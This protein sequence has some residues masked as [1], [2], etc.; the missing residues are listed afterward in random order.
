MSTDY[1]LKT[2]DYRL[3]LLV[4]GKKPGT[5]DLQI[6]EDRRLRTDRKTERTVRPNRHYVNE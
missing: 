1:R 4:S 2:N 3:D 5:V 6:L